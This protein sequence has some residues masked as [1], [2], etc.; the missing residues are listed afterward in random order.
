MKQELVSIMMNYH[1][2]NSID[3]LFNYILNSV[4]KGNK[5]HK[6]FQCKYMVKDKVIKDIK[7]YVFD[8]DINS[9]STL[10]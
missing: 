4:D 1:Q 10:F 8:S 9:D 7:K 5:I 6:I 2:K 3:S